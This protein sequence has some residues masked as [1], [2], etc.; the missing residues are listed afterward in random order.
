MSL[1]AM[2]TGKGSPGATF[3]GINLCRAL[4][5][6]G[7][8]VLYVD[9]DAA[10]GDAIC[11]LGLD[12]RKGLDTLSRLP[13]QDLGSPEVLMG[14]AEKRD[15]AYYLA[16]FAASGTISKEIAERVFEGLRQVDYLV[17][18]DLGRVDATTNFVAAGADLVLVVVRP[19]A[20]SAYGAQ[21]AIQALEDCG[22]PRQRIAGVVNGRLPWRRPQL[23]DISQVLRVRVITRTIPYYLVSGPRALDAQ[24]P[25]RIRS[26]KRAFGELAEEVL[27][28]LADARPNLTLTEL[29]DGVTVK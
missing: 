4:A 19:D 26:A 23:S 17:V 22:V 21:R 15:G 1:I 11:Y 12:P 29:D 25:L 28:I 8:Q 2:C 5:A 3:L 16:G 13:D 14:D 7:N 27:A 10:G 9:L 18:V 20:A 24:T 6:K